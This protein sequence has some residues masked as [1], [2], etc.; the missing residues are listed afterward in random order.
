M[1]DAIVGG[2]SLLELFWYFVGYS[3]LGWLLEVAYAYVKEKRFVNRGFLFGPFCPIYGLGVTSIILAA[4][5]FGL[6]S[7]VYNLKN[8]LT[9]FVLVAVLSTVLE[10]LVGALLMLFFRQRWWDYSDRP[11]NV[12]GYI[13]LRF[14]FYWGIGGSLLY[15][16]L[17]FLGWNKNLVLARPL[18][19]YLTLVVFLYFVVDAT[20]SVDL[21]IRLRRFVLELA[22]AAKELRERIESLPELGLDYLRVETAIR[23]GKLHE[24][25]EEFSEHMSQVGV[26]SRVKLKQS[27]NRY[28]A[29]YVSGRIRQFRH[30]VRAFPSIRDIRHAEIMEMVKERINLPKVTIRIEKRGQKSMAVPTVGHIED[31]ENVQVDSV[32]AKATWMRRLIGPENGWDG[33]AMRLF[34]VEPGGHT[35]RHAHDWPHINLVLSGEG[36]LFVNDREEAIEKGSYAYLPGGTKHQFRNTGSVPLEFMCIVP[37]EE[38]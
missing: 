18:F 34:T 13:C 28:E 31:V 1:L 16:L 15:L 3:F 23:R 8:L 30:I 11:F 22:E 10:F 36:T 35:P 6:H 14:S 7:F 5:M 20:K 21:A 32:E 37:E 24:G 19:D 29:L 27:M 26:E 2:Y 25:M 17:S 38:K 33:Y 9:L 4:S 12:K